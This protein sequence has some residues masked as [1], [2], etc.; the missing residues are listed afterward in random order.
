MSSMLISNLLEYSFLFPLF[1]LLILTTSDFLYLNVLDDIGNVTFTTFH[2]CNKTTV[3]HNFA[4]KVFFFIPADV[5]IA[6]NDRVLT[7]ANVR[8]VWLFVFQT[9]LFFS[10][11]NR[12]EADKML[13]IAAKTRAL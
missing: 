8:F 12:L 1:L 7:K 6:Y 2:Y 10:K 11:I 4:Q 3:R 9:R 13:A 5:N